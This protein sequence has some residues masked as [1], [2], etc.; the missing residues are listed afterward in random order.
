MTKILVGSRAFFGGVNGFKS[1][2]R[3]FVKLVTNSAP[4]RIESKLSVHGNIIYRLLRE[5]AS[6]MVQKAIESGNGL[7]FG[8]FIVPAF[9][10]EIG[11]SIDDLKKL[12][13]LLSALN[14]KHSYQSVIYNYYLANG[15]FTLTDEQRA[16]AY[17]VYMA[18]R[19]P[20]KQK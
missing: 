18:A 20:N 9:A 3:N 5:P 19:V 6:V 13:P 4:L 2:N 17:S 11:L 15:S 14:Q 16:E 10:K 8:N 1:D 7:L 12:Q